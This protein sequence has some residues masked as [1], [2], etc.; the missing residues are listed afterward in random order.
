MAPAKPPPFEEFD[1]KV[2]PVISMVLDRA[3]MAPPEE[4]LAVLPVKVQFATCRKPRRLKTAP[5]P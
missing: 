4:L 5:P 2:L 1:M 3:W